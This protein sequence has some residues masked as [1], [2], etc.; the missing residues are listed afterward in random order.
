MR[1]QTSTHSW[2]SSL[3]HRAG[4]LPQCIMA[5]NGKRSPELAKSNGF[6]KETT[7]PATTIVAAAA[8]VKENTLTC[9]LCRLSQ[10]GCGLQHGDSLLAFSTSPRSS[11]GCSSSLLYSVLQT[12]NICV[13]ENRFFQGSV[14]SSS[15]EDNS[16]DLT[17]QTS[18]TFQLKASR[19][20]T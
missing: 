4:Q 14:R 16:S 20:G 17:R 8:T 11:V 6:A 3:T 18:R 7:A 15:E 10:F 12:G 5:G 1:T 19:Y 13:M 9:S 2:R